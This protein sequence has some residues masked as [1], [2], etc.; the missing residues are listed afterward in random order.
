MRFNG[1][2]KEGRKRKGREQEE[3]K[4]TGDRETGSKKEPQS[5]R[6]YPDVGIFPPSKTIAASCG[7]GGGGVQKCNAMRLRAVLKF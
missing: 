6:R 5:R 7:G 2:G 1:R 4:N 3:E